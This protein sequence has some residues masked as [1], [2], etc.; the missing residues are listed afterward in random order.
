MDAVT[1]PDVLFLEFICRVVLLTKGK[2]VHKHP[3]SN[4]RTVYAT[5][6]CYIDV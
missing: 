6:R 2:G 1:A 3:F 5:A 4:G